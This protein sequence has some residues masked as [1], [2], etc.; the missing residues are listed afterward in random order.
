MCP[1]C[2]LV[3]SAA[4]IRTCS[5]LFF[6]HF[7]CLI[8]DRFR[9]LPGIHFDF[10]VPS[11]FSF[12]VSFFTIFICLLYVRFS[13]FCGDPG[14]EN[15]KANST[16]VGVM[17]MIKDGAASAYSVQSPRGLFSYLRGRMNVRHLS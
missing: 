14:D 11:L 15:K 5:F 2:D 6:S 9:F 13:V 17:I 7:S 8:W 1:D 3:S 4:L 16:V 12:M 10:F